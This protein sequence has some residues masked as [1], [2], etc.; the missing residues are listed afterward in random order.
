MSFGKHH[1]YYYSEYIIHQEIN[2]QKKLIN[3]YLNSKSLYWKFLFR[4]ETKH[5]SKPYGP[6]EHIYK[7][8]IFFKGCTIYICI[9]LKKNFFQIFAFL[10]KLDNCYYL[11]TFTRNY[12]KYHY[13]FYNVWILTEFLKIFAFHFYKV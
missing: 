12:F 3:N 4:A 6:R 13:L 9:K 10:P 8:A 2:C 1:H 11:A 7:Q 5:I